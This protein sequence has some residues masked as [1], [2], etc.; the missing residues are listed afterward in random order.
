MCSYTAFIGQAIPGMR[1]CPCCGQPM[2]EMDDE[3]ADCIAAPVVTGTCPDCGA[4]F[5]Y[6]E[7][8]HFTFREHREHGT[9]YCWDCR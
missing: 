3:C 9:R 6:V 4:S 5:D 8:M 2:P 1:P 7:R